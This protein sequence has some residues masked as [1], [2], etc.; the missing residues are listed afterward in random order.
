MDLGDYYQNRYGNDYYAQLDYTNT[1][2]ED[3]LLGRFGEN[4]FYASACSG[5]GFKFAPWIGR[6]LAD[7]ADG[8]D[9]PELYSRFCTG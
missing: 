4:G 2:N 3:F 7:F 9:C 8:T 1:P 6:L 5:H